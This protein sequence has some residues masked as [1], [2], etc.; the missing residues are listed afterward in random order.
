MANSGATLTYAEL[1]ARSNQA[2]QLYRTCGL[3][4]GDTLAIF[5]ENHLDYLPLCWGA[6]RSGL[7][8]NAAFDADK[9]SYDADYQNEQAHSGQ[10]QKHLSDVE[11]II[12]KHFKGQELIEVGCGKGYFL[13]L[14]KGL[15]YSITG[16]D[17]AYEGE[18]ADVRNTP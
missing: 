11:G 6:Q 8:F 17:P 14:L 18:N 2:A 1:E 9:L 16:I 12:A 4:R 15:G 13:E 3:R 7:I 5:L 10:F